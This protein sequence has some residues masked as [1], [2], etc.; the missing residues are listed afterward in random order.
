M[1]VRNHLRKL[2]L[3]LSPN[4]LIGL[5]DA[6]HVCAHV[7]ALGG[8]HLLLTM[9]WPTGPVKGASLDRCEGY[10]NIELAGYGHHG[11]QQ[12]TAT[13]LFPTRIFCAVR[14]AFRVKRAVLCN[15]C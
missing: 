2:V 3:V 14:D 15:V 11:L 4:E 5:T 10:W 12:S 13:F 6:T 9:L 1:V 7:V 8:C